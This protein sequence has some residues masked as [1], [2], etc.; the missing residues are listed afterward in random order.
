M[1]R[2]KGQC[3]NF[4]KTKIEGTRTRRYLI[5]KARFGNPTRGEDNEGSGGIFKDGPME[6]KEMRI[7]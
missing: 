5:S 4:T 2:E 7:G 3:S 6:K 1:T